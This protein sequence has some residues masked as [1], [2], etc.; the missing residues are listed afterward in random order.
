M[1]TLINPH[2]F[3]LGVGLT[4]TVLTSGTD[5]VDTTGGFLTASVALAAAKLYTLAFAT[6]RDSGSQGSSTATQTGATWTQVQTSSYSSDNTRLTVFRCQPASAVASATI[7][8]ENPDPITSDW[9]QWILV[10]WDGA[11]DD[12]ANNGAGAIVQIGTFSASSNSPN[13]NLPSPLASSLNAGLVFGVHSNTTSLVARSP[14]LQIG[15]V[16]VGVVHLAGVWGL[17]VRQPILDA[18]T[19]ALSCAVG[20]EIKD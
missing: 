18:T 11:F 3:G 1:S 14:G 16:N 2:R 12:S 8:V 4:P 9:G 15:A 10:E 19:T 13:V 17:D 6:R 5:D 7:T 20:L